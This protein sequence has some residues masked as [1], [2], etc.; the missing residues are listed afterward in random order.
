MKWVTDMVGIA[1][2]ESDIAIHAMSQEDESDYQHNLNT[3]VLSLMLSKT[4]DL[5]KDDAHTLGVAALFHDIGKLK[6]QPE[7]LRKPSLI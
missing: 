1:L 7:I 4:L 5:S 6:I 3:M 2:T